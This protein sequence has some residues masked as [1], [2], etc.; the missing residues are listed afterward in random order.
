[1]APGD[2]RVVVAHRRRLYAYR[3]AD[4]LP[5]RLRPPPL[6]RYPRFKTVEF[7]TSFPDGCLHQ[8]DHGDD[9]MP[10]RLENQL[11]AHPK[12]QMDHYCA[13]SGSGFFTPTIAFSAPYLICSHCAGPKSEIRR[14][15][16]TTIPIEPAVLTSVSP[17]P[18]PPSLSPRKPFNAE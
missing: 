9:D 15:L 12:F 16:N 14:V 1:L 17:S 13:N 11:H 5:L 3:P 18:T 6:I 10:G 8:H 2:C 7:L 4:P